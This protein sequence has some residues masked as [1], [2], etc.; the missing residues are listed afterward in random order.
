MISLVIASA[1]L[2]VW[3]YLAVAR[4]RFWRA[5]TDD[6]RAGVPAPAA[7]PDVIAI[8]PARD[9]ADVV[10]ATVG[11]LLAQDYPGSFA[12]VLVDDQSQDG[13]A[14]VA[15]DAAAAVGAAH[16]LTVLSGRTPPTG[17]SGK[18]WAMQQGVEHVDALSRPRAICCSPTPTSSTSATRCGSSSPRP[19]PMVSC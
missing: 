9:E 11:S 16:R 13:T 5:S 19:R 10:G 1:A 8:V 18:V 6:D 2:A 3:L 7:W 17:W 12:I 14:A 4:G 15:R